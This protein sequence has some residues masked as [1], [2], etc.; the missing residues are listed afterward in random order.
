MTKVD[1]LSLSSNVHH[2]RLAQQQLL[3]ELTSNKLEEQQS[4]SVLLSHKKT[5][6]QMTLVELRDLCKQYQIPSS[7]A[8][9]TK[10]I[11]RIKQAQNKV[12][13]QGNSTFIL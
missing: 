5:L 2:I 6:E 7:H 4:S 10:L 9:K 1:S 12:I 8:N 3:L 13:N 11:Q